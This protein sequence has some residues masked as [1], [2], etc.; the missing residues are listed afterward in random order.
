MSGVT[1]YL[2]LGCSTSKR[3]VA[4]LMECYKNTHVYHRRDLNALRKL[5]REISSGSFGGLLI[6][7]CS[8]EDL[9]LVKQCIKSPEF[10]NAELVLLRNSDFPR[11]RSFFDVVFGLGLAQKVCECGG[12]SVVLVSQPINALEGARSF[13][14]RIEDPATVDQTA[15]LIHGYR[16]RFEFSIDRSLRIGTQRA[17]LEP[18]QALRYS[19]RWGKYSIDQRKEFRDLVSQEF[20]T[21]DSE[22]EF[23]DICR[24]SLPSE[25]EKVKLGRSKVV[26]LGT[27]RLCRRLSTM[28]LEGSPLSFSLVLGPCHDEP[29]AGLNIR[30]LFSVGVRSFDF[31]NLESIRHQVE[32]VQSQLAIVFVDALSG[33][34]TC[35]Y[36]FTKK[37]QLEENRMGVLA[38]IGN[39][40]RGIVV[41][42]RGG[43]YVEVYGKRGLQL[44]FD[45]FRWH[46]HP[47]AV[48]DKALDEHF[49]GAGLADS[50]KSRL[51]DAICNLMDMQYASIIALVK[52]NKLRECEKFLKALRPESRIE[53]RISADDLPAETIASLLRLDGAHLIDEN[54][55]L[56]KI[57]QG[58][59][60]RQGDRLGPPYGPGMGVRAA[61]RLSANVKDGCLVIKVSASGQ[62]KIFKAGH[63]M[64]ARM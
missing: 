42:V 19:E 47:F 53:D 16:S 36:G 35:V 24:E 23:Y 60:E 29:P 64:T 22:Q 37:A 33:K 4:I 56:M 2:D 26:A 10:L 44:W 28:T 49:R 20:T 61:Q 51:R 12:Q 11:N 14:F 3:I 58:I 7:A 27:I 8:D 46:A 25:D 15:F 17:F 1:Y 55:K 18:T 13:A 52:R 54:F 6:V 32:M 59:V 50:W 62:L 21:V 34:L 43:G 31:Q 48:L 57:C 40:F 9:P 45:G 5:A 38:G 63:Q 41:H 39:G 30:Q